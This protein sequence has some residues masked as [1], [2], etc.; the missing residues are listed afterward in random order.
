MK[1]IL[2]INNEL[3][4]SVIM[5]RENT[6]ERGA[7]R[8]Q[9][10]W[11]SVNISSEICFGSIKKYIHNYIFLVFELQ[12]S[13]G[14]SASAITQIHTLKFCLI[15]KVIFIKIKKIIIIGK[16]PAEMLSKSSHLWKG[17]NQQHLANILTREA[18]A[19][20]LLPAHADAL[21]P[22]NRLQ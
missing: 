22:I 13:P 21:V 6:K 4:A 18:H 2:I 7:F 16:K 12:I 17:G 1:L 8:M 20:I 15:H 19:G 3:F 5:N 11:L 14:R 9:N 10:C